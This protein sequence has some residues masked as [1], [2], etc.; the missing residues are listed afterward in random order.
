MGDRQHVLRGRPIRGFIRIE[1]VLY[2]PFEGYAH[3]VGLWKSVFCVTNNIKLYTQNTPNFGA[4]GD[5]NISLYVSV[6]LMK[7]G[8]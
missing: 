3:L 1:H 7:S 4:F 5:V 2:A 8:S 6:E